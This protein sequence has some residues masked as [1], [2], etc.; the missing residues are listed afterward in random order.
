MQLSGRG[1]DDPNSSSVTTRRRHMHLLR[2]SIVP[3]GFLLLAAWIS[4]ESLQM[5][6][7]TLHMPGAGFFPLVLGLLLGLLALLLSAV[8]RL[9]AASDDTGAPTDWR[10]AICLGASVLA[11]AWLFERTGFLV[12]MAAFLTVTTAVLGGIGWWRSAVMAVVGSAIAWVVF[13]RVL[14]IALPSGIMPM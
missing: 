2:A 1:H 5:P 8:E 10:G 6:L 14:K 12:T 7:G 9:A 11:A 4:H 3:L 13:V